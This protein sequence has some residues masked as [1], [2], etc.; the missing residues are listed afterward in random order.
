MPKPLSDAQRMKNKRAIAKDLGLCQKCF[1]R[2]AMPRV[3]GQDWPR[4]TLCG[5]CDEAQEDYRVG[6]AHSLEVAHA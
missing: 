4:R 5:V 6:L 1:K 2:D 3:L